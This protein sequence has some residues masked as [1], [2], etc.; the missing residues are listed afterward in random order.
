[1]EPIDGLIL[2]MAHPDAIDGVRRTGKAFCE[3]FIEAL[4]NLH[5]VDFEHAGL[6]DLGRPDGYVERQVKGW[7]KRYNASKI[8]D[9]AAADEIG[10]WLLEHMPPQ[11]IAALI[12]NDYHLGNVVL[13]PH[14]CCS[15]IGVLDWEMCTIGDPLMDLGTTLSYWIESDDPE[16]IQKIRNLVPTLPGF[17]SRRE[18]AEHYARRSGKHL[19]DIVFY[20][21]FGL[22][23]VGV[24]VQQIYYRFKAGLTREPRFAAYLDVA[25]ALINTAIYVARSGQL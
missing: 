14:D 5:S 24:I 8:E 25:K 10:N 19:D 2:D 22:F 3:S 6:A 23:K 20:Y 1:M 15:I 17:M 21:A 4:A 9:I 18:L 11:Y 16:E 12:H 13:D 7:I